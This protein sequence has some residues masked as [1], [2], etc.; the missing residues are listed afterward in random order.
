VDAVLGGWQL[1][2]IF[3]WNSGFPTGANN[4]PFGFQRWPTNWQLSS[5]MVRVR[6]LE[7]S[8]SNNVN[9]EPNIF[10]DPTAAYLSFRDARPGEAGDRNVF[11]LPGYISLDAGLYKRFK[12]PW[13][14][15]A[16]TFRWEVYNVTNTQ[17]LTTPSG[18][19]ISAV[20][21]YLSGQFGL[22]AVS[23]APPD[24]GRFTATQTPLNETKA[25]RVMQFALR[26]TF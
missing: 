15:H 23:Q 16:I 3:R 9:G 20:D 12:M 2:G 18:F 8:P 17:R 5:G 24:F 11:R 4:R 22:P 1:T 6:P 7:S 25:G 26:Y 10:S 14:N 13:E 19:A 21:P